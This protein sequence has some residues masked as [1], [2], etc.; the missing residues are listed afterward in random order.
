MSHDHS[1]S[2]LEEPAM[3]TSKTFG[4][5]LEG[6]AYSARPAAYTV[7]GG[8][9]G[10][11]GAVLGPSGMIWLPGGGSL[12]G[13]SPEQTVIREVREELARKVRLVG[14][15]GVATQFFYASDDAR[16]YEMLAVFFL[17]EFPDEPNGQGEHR[18]YWLPLAEAE[19]TFFH[20]SH[21]WAARQGLDIFEKG[22]KA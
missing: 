11:V 22:P 2:I 21:A 14:K 7:V 10:T 9:N 13:E 15:I 12:P 17:A 4:T 18:L 5:R 6:V 16:Y 8:Q 1:E 3:P 20:E 19:R